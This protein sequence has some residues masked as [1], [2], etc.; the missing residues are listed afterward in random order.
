MIRYL[1]TYENFFWLPKENES[2]NVSLVIGFEGD[3]N[4]FLVRRAL[5]LLQKK[6]SVLRVEVVNSN[7]PFYSFTNERK[8][9][10]KVINN[11]SWKK[12]LKKEIHKPFSLDGCPLIR[13]VFLS[14]QSGKKAFILTTHHLI[15]DGISLSFFAKDLLSTISSIKSGEKID[16]EENDIPPTIFKNYL[17]KSKV[18]ISKGSIF[19]NKSFPKIKRKKTRK[20]NTGLIHK[21]LNVSLFK[22][23]KKISKLKKIKIHSIFTTAMLF[24]FFKEINN[25]SFNRNKKEIVY[26]SPVN[27]RKFAKIPL[28]RL[29]CFISILCFKEVFD[30]GRSFWSYAKKINDRLHE[31]LESSLLNETMESI[32]SDN[33]KLYRFFYIKI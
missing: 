8:I 1:D 2:F 13:L 22:K 21:S 4:P 12:E 17:S 33:G 6:Y 7:N 28:E 23:I 11:F 16:F 10:L 25:T 18:S 3:L 14:D 9:D 32:K 29:G 31:K 5:D 27:L 19:A 20:I 30:Q 26:E 24:S 15:N